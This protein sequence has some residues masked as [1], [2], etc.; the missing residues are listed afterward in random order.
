[1]IK[2]WTEAM[3]LMVE[4]D[5]WEMCATPRERVTPCGSCCP[6]MRRRY[7][8]SE[9]GYGDSGSPPKIK[10]GDPLVFQMEIIKIKVRGRGGHGCRVRGSRGWWGVACCASLVYFG[11]ERGKAVDF[12]FVLQGDK[13]P[14][15]KC[16]PT[17]AAAESGCRYAHPQ[18]SRCL[19]RVA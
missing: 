16:D 3:Q 11:S 5:K 13:K 7:I 1:V 18:T 17:K 12:L 10:G 19:L 4:G 14:A 9:L 15:L 6:S 2:G 8:P